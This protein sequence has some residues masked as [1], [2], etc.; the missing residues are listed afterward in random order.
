MI[1]SSSWWDPYNRYDLVHISF[2]DAAQHFT[3]VGE[4]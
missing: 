3:E 1:Y 4:K 2:V